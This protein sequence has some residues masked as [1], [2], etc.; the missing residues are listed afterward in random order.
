MSVR[1]L[2]RDRS[3]VIAAVCSVI[4]H[5]NGRDLHAIN[6]PRSNYVTRANTQLLIF[7]HARHSRL[8]GVN[9]KGTL[10]ILD[11]CFYLFCVSDKF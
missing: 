2:R 4:Q 8:K 9:R 10:A 11:L 6:V 7:G 5:G 3:R 1:K